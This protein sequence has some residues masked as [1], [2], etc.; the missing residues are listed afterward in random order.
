MD[1][2]WISKLSI[3]VKLHLSQSHLSFPPCFMV[4]GN[5][6]VLVYATLMGSIVGW[7]LR[8]PSIAWKFDHNLRNGTLPVRAFQPIPGRSILFCFNW[9]IHD[10]GAMTSMCIDPSQSWLAVG[11][12]KGM[13]VCWDLRFRL[14]VATLSHPASSR[15]LRLLSHPTQPSCF[16][17]SAQ[18]NNEVSVWDWESQSRS[19]T[20]WA[21]SA[22]PLSNQQGQSYNAHGCFAG[23]RAG[24]SPFV[25][26][27]GSDLRLRYWDLTNP[28]H[29][30]LI[31]RGPYDPLHNQD[32]SYE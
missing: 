24:S 23:C 22:P 19:L 21:S 7:D 14:P 17:S 31:S 18:S 9:S 28:D 4:L 12:D 6:S 32:V 5:Q 30:A 1:L 27:G 20:L 8:S 16:I 2:L 25:L 26:T 29:S 3:V 10:T 13:H 15:I 11:T